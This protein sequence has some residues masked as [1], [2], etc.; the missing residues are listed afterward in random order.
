M[1]R[2]RHVLLHLVEAPAFDDLG[3]VFLAVDHALIQ[4]GID[5]AEAERRGIGAER[6]EHLDALAAGGRADLEPVQ[7]GGHHDGP[8]T[9]GDLAEAV[10]PHRGQHHAGALE[11]FGQHLARR[12]GGKGLHGVAVLEQ[13][14][15]IEDG[16]A[17][18]DL[19]DGR[20]GKRCLMRTETEALEDVLLR[21]ER[22]RHEDLHVD[23]AVGGGFEPGFVFLQ[24]DMREG[25]F[26]QGGVDLQH[27]LGGGHARQ[28]EA[29]GRDEKG[30]SQK[31]HVAI[32]SYGGGRASDVLRKR[33]FTSHVV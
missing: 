21:A 2:Q 27:G 32:L 3:G 20:R 11:A 19:R 24:E 17:G 4:P 14:G 33:F 22:V 23:G 8:H 5:L 7:I 26:R 6:V 12:A 25:A 13:I 30:F 28:G 29:R 16:G 15:E 1:V 9:V 10:V 31:G 18:V